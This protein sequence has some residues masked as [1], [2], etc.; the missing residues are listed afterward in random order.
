M[1]A[2][3][4]LARDHGFEDAGELSVATLKFLPEVRSMCAANTCRSYGK[5]WTCP[6]HCGTLDESTRKVAAFERG[7]LVQ[8]VGK[9]DDD[10]DYES[11]EAAQ[12]LHNQRFHQLVGD[13][14]G[15]VPHCLPMGAGAC[16]LCAECPCPAEPCRFPDKAIVSME[17]Y[18]LFV[19]QV[20]EANGIPYNHG[21]LT[22]TFTSCLLTHFPQSI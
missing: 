4:Q 18:G 5:N 1:T 13:V 7:I 8:T 14:R 17:A 21:S 15:T 10:F 19:S 12:A 9:L 22:V 20:C 3:L 6:P 2:L 11:M 16:T